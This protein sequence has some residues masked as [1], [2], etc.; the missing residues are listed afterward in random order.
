MVARALLP[1]SGSVA[2][3]IQVVRCYIAMPNFNSSQGGE[4]PMLAQRS[5]ERNTSLQHA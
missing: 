4:R 5:I 1:V 3:A 2:P